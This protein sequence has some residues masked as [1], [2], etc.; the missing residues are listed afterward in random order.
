MEPGGSVDSGRLVSVAVGL[1]G[2]RH[3][4]VSLSFWR[5]GAR[6]RGG[7]PDK[8]K[9]LITPQD[10]VGHLVGSSRVSDQLTV[11]VMKLSASSL[12]VGSR[13]PA[14]PVPDVGEL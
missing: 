12:R 10:I 3:Y 2:P 5:R 8:G 13:G 6:R 4:G 11:Q 14:N 1:L 9:F 7:G